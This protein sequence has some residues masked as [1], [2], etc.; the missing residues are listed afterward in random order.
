MYAIRKSLA[1]V[2]GPLQMHMVH[3]QKPRPARPLVTIRSR[4]FRP[5]RGQ[6]LNYLVRLYALKK[7]RT[8]SAAIVRG[9]NA[10]VFFL[11]MTMYQ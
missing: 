8:M 10:A 5:E 3:R 7:A 11:P 4:Q 1:G 2:K 6:N 9:M